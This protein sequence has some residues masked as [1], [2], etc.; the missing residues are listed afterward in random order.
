MD[1]RVPQMAPQSPPRDSEMTPNRFLNELS[2]LRH[3]SG[4]PKQQVFLLTGGFEWVSLVGP[5]SHDGGGF[6]DGWCMHVKKWFSISFSQETEDFCG[7]IGSDPTT[8]HAHVCG[9]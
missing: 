2:G 8:F 9:Y 6:L 4:R 1:D 5:L 3:E 7:L